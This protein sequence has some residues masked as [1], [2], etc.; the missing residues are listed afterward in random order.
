MT[1]QRE[2]AVQAEE[3]DG[4]DRPTG[5]YTW[6]YVPT[7]AQTAFHA[8]R[9]AGGAV[10]PRINRM[11]GGAAGP[12]KSHAERWD[13]YRK[14][15]SI[16]G[17]VG[18]ILRRTMP[19]LRKT[20]LRSFARDADK[21]GAQFL[22]SENQLVWENGS[23]IECGHCEDDDAVS[24]WLS[25]EYDQIGI[26]EGSTFPGD[27]LLEISTRARTSNPLVKA[28]G[29][30]WF[31]VVTNP[32]GRSWALLRDLF[33]T[34]TPDFDLYP[35]LKATYDPSHWVYIKA[36][37]DGNPYLDA[38]YADDLR[39]LSDARYRQLRF[40]EEFVTDGAFFSQWRETKD[41]EPWHVRDLDLPTD[42]SWA[43]GMDW[44]YN[45]PG[46]VL[47]VAILP[48]GRYHVADEWKFQGQTADEVATAIQRKNKALGITNLR[49][50]VCDPA[51]KQKTG[52]GRGESI[53]ETLRRRGLPMR[54]GD[55]D[56]FNGW[57]RVQQLLRAAPDDRPWLTVSPACRYGRRT[58]P[59]QVQ[60]KH[61]PDDLDTNKDDHWADA[62]RYFCQSR[63]APT[64]PQRAPE[65][66]YPVNSWGWARQRYE[67]AQR[68]KGI[69]A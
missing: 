60:D 6:L 21:I 35:Q 58:M 42:T 24:K 9:R 41:G 64:G 23:L 3:R 51:M 15:M 36:L 33:V 40:G 50:L 5:R 67:A 28:A 48:D 47:W 11:Y 55:N 54:P 57:Q 66:E 68:P 14:A 16:P 63:P 39:V 52:A 62:L 59:A 29:G 53:F 56:R 2:W 43:A 38:S 22:K 69:L 13:Q 8:V 44:G 4:R 25:S 32:G 18:L 37:L 20:H 45:A 26:D 7:P 49:Y 12:G 27:H 10:G 34:Q 1:R 31:D 65:P 61:D 46:V 30:A 17:F 19:E